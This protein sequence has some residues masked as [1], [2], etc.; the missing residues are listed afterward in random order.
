MSKFDSKFLK[1]S[2]EIFEEQNK[3]M[4]NNNKMNILNLKEAKI[5]SNN[6]NILLSKINNLEKNLKIINEKKPV[7]KI[8]EVPVEKVVEKIIKVPVEKVVEKIIE[9]PVEKIVEKIVE[10]P[11]E[12][13]VEKIVEVP[14]GKINDD[15][16]KEKKTYEVKDKLQL[17]ILE[18]ENEPTFR[19]YDYF[20]LPNNTN[21]VDVIS[22][23]EIISKF[24]KLIDG[25]N[26]N[27]EFKY[28]IT[29]NNIFVEDYNKENEKIKKTI[30]GK[31]VSLN[32]KY[33]DINI[34]GSKFNKFIFFDDH[35]KEIFIDKI[36]VNEY[37]YDIISKDDAILIGKKY[38]GSDDVILDAKLCYYNFENNKYIV[39][40]YIISGEKNGKKL[41]DH[42]VPAINSHIPN[43]DVN[44]LSI[45]RV[46][47][48]KDNEKFNIK[49]GHVYSDFNIEVISIFEI[50][51]N[52][53]NDSSIDIIIPKNIYIENYKNLNEITILLSVMNNYGFVNYM[54]ILI[55]LEPYKSLFKI[56]KVSNN[57]SSN[58][59]NHGVFW[60]EKLSGLLYARYCNEI[61]KNNVKKEF[62]IDRKLEDNYLMDID[63]E[64]S[65]GND[66]ILENENFDNNNLEFKILMA[67]ESLK[68]KNWY[69]TYSKFFNKLHLLCGFENNASVGSYNMLKY[70]IENQYSKNQTIM[71][72]WLNAGICDQLQG[73]KL[74]IIGALINDNNK[75]YKSIDSAIPSLYRANW[76]DFN[77]GVN[78]GPGLDV[79]KLKV[80]GYWK[81][82]MII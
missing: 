38:Y 79:N 72:S 44:N 33:K 11:V 43:I 8:V 64:I 78:D 49:I 50:V 32:I 5:R 66:R 9:V 63:T 37:K 15:K 59:N 51:N 16:V 42:I 70:F 61:K 54:K 39:P 7:E 24:K 21:K 56:K 74:V 40:S 3:R 75:N 73:T 19:E 65:I 71:S 68:D 76:N 48:D 20:D 17:P 62:V 82:V 2:S 36:K 6:D 18:Y 60:T 26:K 23:E 27:E 13:I 45:S 31:N 25:F 14:I 35:D 53:K 77:W 41:L 1:L 30:F 67:S 10:V 34:L 4:C 22:N 58:I 57:T 47:N 12:K 29:V 46:T 28:N 69:N 81:L 52:I 80:K 55:N